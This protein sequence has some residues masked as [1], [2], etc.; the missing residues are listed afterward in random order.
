MTATKVEAVQAA[1][2]PGSYLLTVTSK[3]KHGSNVHDDDDAKYVDPG[4]RSGSGCNWCNWRDRQGS[5]G[6]TGTR[7]CGSWDPQ[8]LRDLRATER[9]RGSCR[10]GGCRARR[11][12]RARIGGIGRLTQ[13]IRREY[14]AQLDDG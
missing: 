13:D 14:D 3:D 2:Q 8:A 5:Q 6:A 12:S 11:S 1:V 7:A 10:P 9:A 4:S